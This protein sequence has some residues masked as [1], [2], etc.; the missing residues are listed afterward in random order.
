MFFFKNKKRKWHGILTKDDNRFVE[1]RVP[2]NSKG[3][4][5]QDIINGCKNPEE[6]YEALEGT[7]D[8]TILP[9]NTKAVI[10]YKDCD[11][12]LIIPADEEKVYQALND[13]DADDI[14]VTLYNR[15]AKIDI[16]MTFHKV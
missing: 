8:M 11:E 9:W 13:I 14:D 12:D 6:S 1:L 15:A 16:P 4:A 7:E 2:E 3:K 10:T 5:A